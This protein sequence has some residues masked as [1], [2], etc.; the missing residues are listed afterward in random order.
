MQTFAHKQKPAAPG[1]S[2]NLQRKQS[3]AVTGPL[4][5]VERTLNDNAQANMVAN[6]QNLFDSS[7]QV[8]SVNAQQTMAASNPGVVAQ[9]KFQNIMNG[10]NDALQVA[11]LKPNGV[12]QRNGDG[13]GDSNWGKKL[14]LG[15]LGGYFAGTRAMAKHTADPLGR[16]GAEQG[17]GFFGM[18]DYV[19]GVNMLKYGQQIFKGGY[20]RYLAMAPMAVASA[21]MLSKLMS[22]KEHK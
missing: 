19:K 4:Q 16:F 2:G 1:R 22:K 13:Q 14:F 9:A 3:G 21:Y 11:Q 5:D 10:R 17:A 20:P 8:S 7:A 12:V 6:Y 15:G 18:G